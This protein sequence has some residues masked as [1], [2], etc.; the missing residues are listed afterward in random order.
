MEISSS[1]PAAPQPAIAQSA[2]PEGFK[3]QDRFAELIVK[4]NNSSGSY[5]EREQMDAWVALH[6]MA[7]TGGLVGMGAENNKLYNE[8]GTRPFPKRSSKLA[9]ATRLR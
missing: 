6:D 9:K 4:V 5:S 2:P 8:S 3:N 7:V 1:P